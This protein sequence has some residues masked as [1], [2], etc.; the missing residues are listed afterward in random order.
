MLRKHVLGLFLPH[1][2]HRQ[3]KAFDITHSENPPTPKIFLQLPLHKD[4][5]DNLALQTLFVYYHLV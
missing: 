1:P 2:P 5:Q 4:S 3:M